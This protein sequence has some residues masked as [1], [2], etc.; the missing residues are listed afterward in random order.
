MGHGEVPFGIREAPARKDDPPIL[1][2][3]KR[4]QVDHL[5]DDAAIRWAR[6]KVLHP[7]VPMVLWRIAGTEREMIWMLAV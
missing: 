3:A 6:D 1:Y 4:L 7:A 2:D 5:D